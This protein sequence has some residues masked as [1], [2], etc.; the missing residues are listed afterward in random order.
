MT[1]DKLLS[2]TITYLRFPLIVGVVFIHFNLVDKGFSANGIN[3]D[4]NG[5]NVDLVR[6]VVLLFSDVLPSLSVPLFFIFS[7]FLFFYN[8]DR[9]DGETYKKKLIKRFWTLA[10]PYFLWNLI[11]FMIKLTTSLSS[12]TLEIHFTLSRLFNT[13]FY[14]D[15]WNGVF[16]LL[17]DT[18]KE[19]YPIDVPMWYVRDLMLM[20]LVSPLIYYVLK[21]ARIWIVL[22]WGGLWYMVKTGTVQSCGFIFI[23]A[24]F[25]FTWGGYYSICRQDFIEDMRRF[26]YAP[27]F[28]VITIMIDLVHGNSFVHCMVIILGVFSVVQIASYLLESGKVKVNKFLADCSF[29]V[30]ALHFLIMKRIATA[31]FSIFHLPNNQYV[32]FMA[33]IIIPTITIVICMLLYSLLKYKLPALCNLMTGGR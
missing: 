6:Y 4:L 3:Y 5:G 17:T 27:L 31:T 33:Y 9:L 11:A 30:F 26:K 20:V 14:C 15:N 24:T 32:L 28:W 13:F 18:N 22:F 21:K 12:K 29:F 1:K 19:A 2:D 23:T 16:V 25:F 8:M 10:I 7:G